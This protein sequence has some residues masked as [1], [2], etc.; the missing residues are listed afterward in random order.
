MFCFLDNL[1]KWSSN[2]IMHQ[3]LLVGEFLIETEIAGLSLPE[4]LNQ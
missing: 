2:F 3:T 4:L 1:D